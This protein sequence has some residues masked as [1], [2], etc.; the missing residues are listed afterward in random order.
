[1]MERTRSFGMIFSTSRIWSCVGGTGTINE[2]NNNALLQN[3]RGHFTIAPENRHSKLC[4]IEGSTKPPSKNRKVLLELVVVVVVV[5]GASV[6]PPLRL[7][8]IRFI[9]ISAASS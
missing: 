4:V 2:L 8:F 3:E 6:C 5:V 9:P 1:M 7:D